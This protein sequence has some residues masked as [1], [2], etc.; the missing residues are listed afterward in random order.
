MKQELFL[1]YYPLYG[2]LAWQ[3]NP[4]RTVPT[5]SYYY[6]INYVTGVTNFHRHQ[7]EGE[8]QDGVV[9]VVAEVGHGGVVVDPRVSSV[10]DSPYFRFDVPASSKRIYLAD[11]LV[12]QY[13]LGA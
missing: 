8:A 12:R 6:A 11:K 3:P 1:G 13:S 7:S 2:T 4:S 9:V 10:L 5:S